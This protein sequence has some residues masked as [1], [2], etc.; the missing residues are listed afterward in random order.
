ML[1]TPGNRKPY[2]FAVN[3]ILLVDLLDEGFEVGKWF[4]CHAWSSSY[5]KLDTHSTTDQ[6]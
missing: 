2:L 6:T 4:L 3:L 1:L 5:L